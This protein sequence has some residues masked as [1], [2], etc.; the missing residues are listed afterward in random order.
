MSNRYNRSPQRYDK[1]VN[2][3][4]FRRRKKK[5]NSSVNRNDKCPHNS[6]IAKL[7]WPDRMVERVHS[8]PYRKKIHSLKITKSHSSH[9][10][11]TYAIQPAIKRKKLI[12]VLHNTVGR[13]YCHFIAIADTKI[14]IVL[15]VPICTEAILI[16]WSLEQNEKKKTI[17]RFSLDDMPHDT[18]QTQ[19]PASK[20]K[21]C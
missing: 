1:T 20:T 4:L 15:D 19:P 5:Q 7:D 8:Y 6:E 12:F 9:P 16:F 21:R 3:N 14:H 13:A 11:H 18:M 2:W 17:H 10:I